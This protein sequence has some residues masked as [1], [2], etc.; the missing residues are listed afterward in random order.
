MTVAPSSLEERAQWV[1]GMLAERDLG[2]ADEIWAPDAVDHFLPVGDAVGRAGIVAFFE[3][4]FGAIPDFTVEVERVIVSA[5]HLVVQWTGSGTFSGS[6]F[7]GIR[8]TGRPVEFRGCDVA[9]VDADGLVVENTIY[10]DGA[11][12]ARQI[13]MLPARGSRGDRL[14]VGAFNAL[15]WVRGIRRP[16]LG[17][18]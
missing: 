1:F 3:E 11:E 9:E 17:R 18:R 4:L 16:R 10:W 6:K 13:G 2:Q 7:Q 14:L 8:A 15:T 5:P 12:F